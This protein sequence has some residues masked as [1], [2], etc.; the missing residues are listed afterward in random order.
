MSQNDCIDGLALLSFDENHRLPR[1]KRVSDITQRTN[2]RSDRS[3]ESDMNSLFGD[4]YGSFGERKS[5]TA[6]V[7]LPDLSIKES[8]CVLRS[9]SQKKKDKA[10]QCDTFDVCDEHFGSFM[11]RKS[12]TA[13]SENHDHG[14]RSHY[15]PKHSSRGKEQR[16]TFERVH[17]VTGKIPLF[18]L[19]ESAKKNGPQGESIHDRSYS[20]RRLSRKKSAV[21]DESTLRGVQ[22]HCLKK[23]HTIKQEY[24]FYAAEAHSP[25]YTPPRA[26]EVIKKCCTTAVGGSPFARALLGGDFSVDTAATGE[27]TYSECKKVK[28]S[29]KRRHE[30]KEV[31]QQAKFFME[32]CKMVS[33]SEFDSKP[34]S[35]LR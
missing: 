17:T 21:H 10:Q 32:S 30:M 9:P 24:D 25:Q 5:S 31:Q 13:N 15:L 26:Q 34:S 2:S 3:M 28:S 4:D 19:A 8:R 18:E 27:T 20:F 11:R 22:V 1:P 23:E 7:V 29:A 16:R 12:S 6:L 33:T 35:S 14:R